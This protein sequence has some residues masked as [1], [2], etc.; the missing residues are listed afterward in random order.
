[1]VTLFEVEPKAFRIQYNYRGYRRKSLVYRGARHEAE[2]IKGNL[3]RLAQFR[4]VGIKPTPDLA[5]WLRSIDAH[6]RDDLAEA[7]MIEAGQTGGALKDLIEYAKRVLFYNIAAHTKANYDQ[8]YKSLI[9]FFGEGRSISTISNGD[10]REFKQWL[11]KPGRVDKTR[12]YG[13]ASIC[14]RIKHSRQIFNLAYQKEW[15]DRNPF[16]G[17]K[18]V[19]KVDPTRRIFID[20]ELAERVLRAIPDSESQLVFALARYAGLRVGS[21]IRALHWSNVDLVEMTMQIWAQKTKSFRVC[22]VFAKLQPYFQKHRAESSPSADLVCP[23]F[24]RSADSAGWVRI[25]SI[26]TKAGIEPWQDFWM[27]CRR[28]AATSVVNEFG[29]KAE[30]VWIGH[31]ETI[32][33]KHYQMVPQELFDQATGKGKTGLR[34]FAG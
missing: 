7:G 30:S 12:G 17:V 1:M 32:S 11:A 34:V 19:A 14:K 25:R 13:S 33:Q 27:N 8:V 26:L 28:S 10:A 22:P 16:V 6:F 15:I 5:T 29:A 2:T 24:C 18:A 31:S 23:R 20:D 21:E 3:I 9:E 4:K